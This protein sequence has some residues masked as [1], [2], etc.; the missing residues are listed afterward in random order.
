LPDVEFLF[1]NQRMS[2][3]GNPSSFNTSFWCWKLLP[4]Q[5]VFRKAL[6]NNTN[7]RFVP[8]RMEKDRDR[9][10]KYW[11]KKESK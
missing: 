4:K 6:N 3:N 2:F 9:I 10:I 8:S 5:I 1:Q 11:E 7:K